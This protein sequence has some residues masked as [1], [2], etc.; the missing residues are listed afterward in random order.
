MSLL[1][2]VYVAAGSFCLYSQEEKVCD[3]FGGLGHA[4]VNP[5]ADG[6]DK[7][8]GDMVDPKA[9]RQSITFS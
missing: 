2:D 1:Q 3:G 8:R 9:V 7:S 4:V 6:F 5:P